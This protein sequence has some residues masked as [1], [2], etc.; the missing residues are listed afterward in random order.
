MARRIVIALGTF[1]AIGLVGALMIPLFH[2]KNPEAAGEALFPVGV[3][4]AVIAFF[5]SQPKNN[6]ERTRA[7]KP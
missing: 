1:I 7:E 4:A 5:L 2:P 6:R 3:V